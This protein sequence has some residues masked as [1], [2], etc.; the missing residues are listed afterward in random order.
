MAITV[1]G[2][3]SCDSCRKAR[4]WLDASGLAYRYHDLRLDGVPEKALQAWVTSAGWEKLL[5]RRS[6]TWR[7]I[8]DVDKDIQAPAQAVALMLEYPTVI[9]RPVICSGRDVLVG[10][11]A[12]EYRRE[13]QGQTG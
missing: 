9:K 7:R 6:A 13:L 1:F 10:F 12:E 2:I 4:Q 11:D 8:P 5:N 3:A